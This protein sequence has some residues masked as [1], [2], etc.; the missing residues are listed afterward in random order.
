M[1]VGVMVDHLPDSPASFTVR[2][3]QLLRAQIRDNGAKRGRRCRDDSHLPQGAPTS[4]AL[5]NLCAYRVDC[6]LSGLARSAGAEY[7]RYADDLAFSGNDDFERR[8]E[9]FS[10][11]VA[12]ILG[13]EGFTVYHRKTR[14][15]RQGVRQHLAGL[16][17]NQ[18]VNVIRTD[19]DRLKAT[20]TNCVRLG[21]ASQNREGH[22]LFRAHL[23]GRVGF[24]ET[25]N[26]A[27]GMRLR[28]IL[29]RIVWP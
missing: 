7:T 22:P 10:T 24:V 11:H 16:V 14:I 28:R 27:K 21:P 8:V 1:I 9:R 13:E 12:A 26:G 6:R 15:M 3:I 29:E 4:P 17:A 23:E 18:S 2:N 25:I 5:A 20:L 19:F